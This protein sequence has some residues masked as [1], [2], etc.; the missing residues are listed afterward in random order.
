M[1]N[2]I[3]EL[4]TYIAEL[5][6]TL[7]S[8][9]LYNFLKDVESLSCFMSYHVYAVWDFMNLLS[10]MQSIYTSV[11]VPWLPPKYPKIARLI[12]EIKLEEE[13]D[14]INGNVTSHFDF[15]MLAMKNIGVNL[16][17][18]EWFMTEIEKG[19]YKTLLTNT[20]LPKGIQS[21]LL[22]T[23]KAIENGPATAAASFTFGRETIIPKMFLKILDNVTLTSEL[24]EFKTYIERHIELDG[25]EHGELSRQLVTEICGDNQRLWQTAAESAKCAIHA[26]IDFYSMIEME[27][28]NKNDN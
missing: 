8:H 1:V 7:F 18:I 12:N 25:E 22:Q 15:Y 6:E 5:K 4:E 28:K 26:R 24:D 10:Y 17:S 23:K 16:N 19:N 27:I 21:F 3:V 11:S 20:A 13:S 2:N 14:I 9:S